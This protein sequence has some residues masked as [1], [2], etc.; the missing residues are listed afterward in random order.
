[1]GFNMRV[2]I[3]GSGGREHALAWKISRSP[4]CQGVFVWPGNA[5][6]LRLA[7]VLDLP[8]DA[9]YG[10]VA[11]AALALKIDMV[12]VGPEGPLSSGITDIMS[13]KGLKVFGPTQ[14]A[15]Q[16]ESSKV[17]AKKLMLEAGIPTSSFEVAKNRQQCSDFALR[18]LNRDGGVVLKASGLASGKGVF[19]CHNEAELQNGIARLYGES[20]KAASDEVVVE[21]LLFGREVSYFCFVG[22]GHVTR[23]GFAVDHKRL[24]VGDKGPNTGGMGCYTPVPWLAVDA[25]DQVD[26]M[27]V[28]PLLEALKRRGIEYTGCLYVGIMWSDKL[29][30]VIEFNVRMGDPEAQVLAVSDSTDWLPL[31]AA[32]VGISLKKMTVVTPPK[33]VMGFVLASSGYPYGDTPDVDAVIPW[34]VL[35]KKEEGPAIFCGSVTPSF[36]GVK[37][38]SGRVFLVA[39]SGETFKSAKLKALEA[40]EGV[41]KHWPQTQW[42]PDI[43]QT[44]LQLEEAQLSSVSRKPIVLGSSSP[45]RRELLGNL[46]LN[47]TVVK[48]ETEEIPL[49]GENPVAYVARNAREK[50][51]WICK[52]IKNTYPDGAVVITADTI[53]VVEQKLLEKPLNPTEAKAM[54]S[55]L[56]GKLHTVYTA[57]RI[58]GLS[59][60]GVQKIIEFTTATSVHIKQLSNSEMD[61]YI[62]TGEPFDKAGGYAAQGLGS[63]MVEEIHGSFSNVVGLPLAELANSLQ[64]DFDIPL[65]R[66]R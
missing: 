16:L 61:G 57:V 23:V 50:G 35:E 36:E 4:E 53:V 43:G 11:S 8:A 51:E 25:G 59:E 19:V 1:M 60:A 63:F 39:A 37:T 26:A 18:V 40:I 3:I 58:S 66:D 5:A 64:N 48:P 34:S 46:G 15:A 9:D 47:F 42:R 45:R 31:M 32:T 28:H 20:L 52:N 27:I 22:S 14:E 54:L 17:F 24:L 55:L 12:V 38:G 44:A 29:P 41:R 30:A 56:S 10:R 6:S 21:E 33:P 13:K 2:L 62:S 49:A 65:W 7:Q